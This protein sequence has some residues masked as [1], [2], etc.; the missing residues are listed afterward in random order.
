[1]VERIGIYGIGL[2]GGSLGLAL[3]TARP[4]VTVIGIGRSAERMQKALDRGAIDSFNVQPA[5]IDPPLDLLVVC[6]PVR[7]VP[8]H[9]RNTLPSLKPGALVTDVGSTKTSVV[10][11]CEKLVG[12]SAAYVGSHPIAGSHNTGI[13]AAADDLFQNKVC[14]VTRTNRTDPAAFDVISDLWKTVG[15]RVVEMSPELHDVLTARTS[16]LPHLLAAVLCHTVGNLG[17]A[18]KP[19]LGN[20]FHDTTRIAAGNPGMWLD[21]CMENRADIIDS[22]KELQSVLQNLHQWLNDSDE[23]AILQFLQQARDWKAAF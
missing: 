16:H 18:V 7:L 9:L 22:L 23:K 1:M 14:V 3:K 19:V 4:Q 8:E 12:A 2:L 20:G 17:P 11:Q 15:M 13:D 21:I 5:G 10:R 6:T